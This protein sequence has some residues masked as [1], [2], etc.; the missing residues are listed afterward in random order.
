[1]LV[2]KPWQ[3][4]VNQLPLDP[5]VSARAVAAQFSLGGVL[6]SFFCMFG[7]SVA[8]EADVSEALLERVFGLACSTCC[9]AVV[10]GDF[11]KTGLATQAVARACGS[12][13]VDAAEACGRPLY[14]SDGADG[15]CRCELCC[16][17]AL[18][19]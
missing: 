9:P 5:L 4:G 3:V 17:R 13:W 12:G 19:S 7:S 10:G 16:A 2:L 1:M 11:N 18:T 6:C 14:T 8:T 15:L